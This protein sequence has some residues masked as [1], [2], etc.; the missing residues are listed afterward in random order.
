MLV[1]ESATGSYLPPALRKTSTPSPYPPQTIIS[2]PVHTV[3]W[4]QA[5]AG[6]A[7]DVDVGRQV[8]DAGS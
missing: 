6:H 5:G 3:L 4:Y 1:Q 7:P 8:S 2:V